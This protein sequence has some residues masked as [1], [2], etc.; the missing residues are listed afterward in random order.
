MSLILASSVVL[1]WA[2]GYFEFS[3]AWVVM[4]AITM[5]YIWQCVLAVPS[6]SRTL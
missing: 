3:V 2:I 6:T 4:L 5:S 1:A